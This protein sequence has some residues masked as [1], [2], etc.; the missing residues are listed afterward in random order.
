MLGLIAQHLQVEEQEKRQQ[1][2]IVAEQAHKRKLWCL[3]VHRRHPVESFVE[4]GANPV[5][6]KLISAMLASQEPVWFDLA[7]EEDLDIQ[8]H[9]DLVH[10]QPNPQT[11]AWG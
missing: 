6:R 3:E 8:L 9:Q 10:H 11:H 7:V 4:F 2:L 5:V 1:L